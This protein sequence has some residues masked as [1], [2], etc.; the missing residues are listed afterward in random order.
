MLMLIESTSEKQ[1]A[2]QKLR[3]IFESAL[4]S[5][6]KLAIGWPGGKMTKP[7]FSN[8]TGKLWYSFALIPKEYGVRRYWNAFGIF[9]PDRGNQIISVEL[10][11][12]TNTNGQQIAGFFAKDTKTNRVYLMHSGRIGGGR[13]GIGKDSF[14]A[15]SRQKLASVADVNGGE[16]F[17]I[18]I[19]QLKKNVIVA[20]VNYFV[21][22]VAD[23][24]ERA[25]NGKLDTQEF[26]RKVK[27]LNRFRRE[28]AGRRR[29]RHGGVVDYIS[30]HG[31]IVN[32]LHDMRKA[33][34]R[35]NEKIL[36]TPLIDLFVKR[37][38]RIIEVYEVKTGTD[39]QAIYTAVGQLM[40]HS[41]GDKQ[42]HKI[43]V[44]P[45]DERLPTGINETLSTLGIDVFR[46]VLDDDGS[47]DF[48]VT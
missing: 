40:V 20:K 10:N 44:L 2:E 27:E 33:R 5:Q 47:V 15:W 31:D 35:P 12:P 19:G 3:H 18:V 37:G 41:K 6:G 46:F 45:A 43:V 21:R 17:G 39:R 13:S 9:D 30:Y 29:G 8:G 28:S 16:R 7:V 4:R 26:R 22:Q 24:K 32:A 1:K 48:T 23:F 38:G 25:A 42:T 11:I 36:N 14:L 34:K